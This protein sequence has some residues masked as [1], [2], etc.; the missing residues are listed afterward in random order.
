[1]WRKGPDTELKNKKTLQEPRKTPVG[2]TNRPNQKWGETQRKTPKGSLL[3][4][5]RWVK[6][7]FKVVFEPSKVQYGRPCFSQG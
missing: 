2:K 5:K 3:N 7:L 1:M 4:I 6:R